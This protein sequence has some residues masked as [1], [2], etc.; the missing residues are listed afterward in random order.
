MA[1][2]YLTRREFGA[3]SLATVTALAVPAAA[4]AQTPS[5]APVSP[6]AAP[7]APPDFIFDAVLK[8]A[9][10]LA[11]A[12]YQAVPENLPKPLADLDYDKYR[13]I[14]FR[15]DKAVWRDQGLPF[16]I[17]LFHLGGFYRRPVVINIIEGEAVRRL[18]FA[19]DLFDYGKNDLG[20]LPADLELAGLR[21]HTP[22]N[23]PTYYDE[24]AVF[25][26]A[27]Y[28]RAVGKG[29]VYGLSARGL[30]IDTALPSGEEFPFFREFW[31]V[32]PASDARE[33]TIY[34]LLDSKS[35]A[36]AY[37]F[38]LV[39]GEATEIGVKAQL[40]MRQDVAKLGLGALTSMYL[41]GEDGMRRFDD[42]RPEV[43]DSDGLLMNASTG[44]WIW[45]PL[46]N[47][48]K[49]RVS[50]FAFDGLKGFGLIQRDRDFRNY[51]DL[52]ALYH[53]RPSC[54]VEMKGN[55][56]QGRVEL[57]E[58]PSEQEKY[59]NVVAFWVPAKS[60]KAKETFAYECQL[61]FA[62]RLAGHSPGGRVSATRTTPGPGGARRFI[63]DFTGGRLPDLKANDPVEIV[64]DA[65]KGNIGLV[66]V[67]RNV[68]TGGWRAFFDL[69]PGDAKSIDLRAFLRLGKDALSETWTYQWIIA[70]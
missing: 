14:R 61:S 49:L 56:G 24:I 21:V 1:G 53:Q 10:S 59:D 64:V 46:G 32:K 45:R 7:A 11:A 36:G 43:H 37:R 40:F 19:Q 15:A 50:A 25:L 30:A 13:D 9:E 34:A 38:V 28:F 2:N 31:V 70:S 4:S 27:S 68:V 16:Q 26:G 58:I 51:E 62:K 55:W 52:E 23:L 57:V 12:D 66:V 69:A 17:Q 5:P 48:R 60:P 39:P 33:L 65:S 67:Q 6:A 20:S 29:Q 63:L 42:F 44:E 54:W 22:M 3:R 47:P 8:R 41:Y 18:G 35:V